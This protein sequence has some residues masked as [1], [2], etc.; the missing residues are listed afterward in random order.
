MTEVRLMHPHVADPPKK[1]NHAILDLVQQSKFFS[2][3]HGIYHVI[4]F[5]NVL[6]HILYSYSVAI[7]VT[8]SFMD[9]FR[10]F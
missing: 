9:H 3:S 5:K 7:L 8:Y 10:I 4:N 1:L 2:Q 6:N